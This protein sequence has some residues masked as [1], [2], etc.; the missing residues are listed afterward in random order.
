VEI[1]LKDS[2]AALVQLGRFHGLWESEQS[3]GTELAEAIRAELRKKAAE[4][5]QRRG[6]KPDASGPGPIE[7]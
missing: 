1:E 6:E 2:F 5:M 4:R 3:K 7:R